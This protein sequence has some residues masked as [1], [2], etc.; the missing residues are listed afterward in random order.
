MP[1]KKNKTTK[2]DAD[3]SHLTIGEFMSAVHLDISNLRDDQYSP[4]DYPSAS[5]LNQAL[6]R[7]ENS[8]TQIMNMAQETSREI[9]ILRAEIDQLRDQLSIVRLFEQA[10][11]VERPQDNHETKGRDIL[12]QL[13][14]TLNEWGTKQ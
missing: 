13:K 1:D 5:V 4:D 3:Y 7:L 10:L 8:R 14:R 12:M 11:N 6:V 2:I 9:R